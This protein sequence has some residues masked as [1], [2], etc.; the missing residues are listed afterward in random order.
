MPNWIHRTTKQVLKSVSP[1][2]LPEAASN[3]IQQPDLSA[4][5]GHPA[6]YWLVRGN[7]VVLV[8][9]TVRAAIDAV[10]ANRNRDNIVDELDETQG[11]MRAFAEVL[12]DEINELRS[13]HILPSKTFPQFKAAVRNKL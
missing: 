5:E 9:A 12:L 8:N 10:E 2:S 11:L 13:Q 3:Y 4:V 1:A 7:D 6:K